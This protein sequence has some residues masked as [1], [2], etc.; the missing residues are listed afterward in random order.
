MSRPPKP[1][2]YVKNPIVRN[3]EPWGRG[4]EMLQTTRG[5]RFRPPTSVSEI[6]G[7]AAAPAA[8]FPA[9]GG[10]YL[11]KISPRAR[12][13]GSARAAVTRRR[14]QVRHQLEQRGHRQP[15]DVEVVA[16]DPGHERRAVALDGVAAR[17]LAPLAAGQIPV[18]E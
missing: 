7:P 4:G 18:D 8:E 14:Q 12:A 6:P 15:D 9:R 1:V 16:L 5:C 2:R 10:R 11:C 17:P 3:E 13:P